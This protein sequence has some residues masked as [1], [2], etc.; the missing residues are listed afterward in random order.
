LRWGVKMR[1]VG[2]FIAFAALAV[3]VA[4]CDPVT[5]RRFVN[6][7]AGVDLYTS[8]RASQVE[9]QNQYFDFICAQAGRGDCNPTT[10]VQ[11]GMN[12]ID[13]RC[14]G[15]LTWLDG[16]RRDKEP[17]LAEIS[18]VNTAVHT[19]MT[20]TG[21]S[22]N[23]LNILTA[24][25]GLASATY[26][27]WNSRLLISVNQSTVQQIVYKGQGDYR[28]KI[29]NY[30]V[31]DRP[32]AIY[33]LRN[34]LRLCMPTTIEASI[35]TTTMLVLNGA[36]EAARQ[37]LVVATTV[38]PLSRVFRESVPNNPRDPLRG[39]GKNNQPLPTFELNMT[40]TDFEK[41]IPQS[42]GKAIQTNLCIMSLTSSFDSAR[43]AIQQAKI[44]ADQTRTRPFAN[45]KNEIVN[46]AEV[47]LLLNATSPPCVFNASEVGPQTA[48]EK[49]RFSDEAAVTSLQQILKVCD[50]SLNISGKFDAP[51]RNAVE[52]AKGKIS[53]PRRAGLTD[54][55]GANLRTLRANSFAAI[56]ATCR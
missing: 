9:L 12:D 25:F 33:L 51:T 28:E 47:Q 30:T 18:A 50:A 46:A 53:Q 48:Y 39:A 32:T 7:G 17:I 42:I 24:V 45:T 8:D 43:D 16:K 5:E 40:G 1:A 20:V 13:L 38:Q 34:Y 6:E 15:F 22:S 55:T 41:T 31:P 37:N 10:F 56:Q 26:A 11:A 21:S 36:P 44:G 54:L 27:N 14:D 3:S 52:V 23:S 35:N 29:K 2:R 4:G 49:F 19:I